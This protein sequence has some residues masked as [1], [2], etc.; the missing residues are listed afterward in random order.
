MRLDTALLN[1]LPVGAD[2]GRLSVARR[3]D[4][5]IVDGLRV[6]QVFVVES[7]SGDR[8][9][10]VVLRDGL[11]DLTPVQAGILLADGANGLEG[12]AIPMSPARYAASPRAVSLVPSGDGAPP[13][14]TPDLAQ[15]HASTGVCASFRDGAPTPTVSLATT[16]DTAVGELAVAASDAAVVVDRIAVQPGRGALVE[17]LPAPNAPRGTLAL[18]SDLGLRFPVPSAD[19]LVTLGYPP[20]VAHPQRLPTALVSL[21]PAGRA[22]DPAAAVRPALM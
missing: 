4:K 20:E 7:Q 14:V 1:A 12:R 10:G 15:I 18:I 16:V 5:S 21:V 3:G 9:Y 17:A 11:A 13:V 22:L 19:V 2:I 6:G 8:H